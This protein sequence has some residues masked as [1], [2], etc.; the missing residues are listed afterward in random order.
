MGTW[1]QAKLPKVLHSVSMQ[2]DGTGKVPMGAVGVE[3]KDGKVRRVLAS[4]IEFA[5]NPFCTALVGQGAR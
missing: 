1:C 4:S 2:S 3:S 5:R